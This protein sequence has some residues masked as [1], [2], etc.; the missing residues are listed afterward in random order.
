MK[1][2]DDLESL[3]SVVVKAGDEAAEADYTEALDD[4][5]GIVQAFEREMYLRQQGPDG[6]P[7]APLALSTILA[8]EHSAIL[9]DTGRMFESLTTP[10]G[11]QDTIW[12]TGKNWLT[13]GTSVPYAHFHQTG[14]RRMPARPHVGVDQQTTDRIGQRMAEAVAQQIGAKI[15][16]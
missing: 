10:N 16:G 8:K 6:T 2:Y 4:A 15:N 9:V 13:F 11:T 12:T 5:I 3:V 1:Q 7:W 14:T